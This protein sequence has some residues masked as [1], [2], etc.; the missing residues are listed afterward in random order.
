MSLSESNSLLVKVKYGARVGDAV[1]SAPAA[2]DTFNSLP[3][4]EYSLP[5]KGF[6]KSLASRRSPHHFH[7]LDK[8][9]AADVSL[10]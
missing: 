4:E 8:N 3:N 6:V 9:A 5:L 2:F 7:P 1:I 10:N